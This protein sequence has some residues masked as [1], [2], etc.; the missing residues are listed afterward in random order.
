MTNN[1]LRKTLEDRKWE[2]DSDIQLNYD[3]RTKPNYP[4][5]Y[6]CQV[7]EMMHKIKQSGEYKIVSSFWCIFTFI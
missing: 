4:H 5:L 1:L 3:H 2:P 6:T 7:C